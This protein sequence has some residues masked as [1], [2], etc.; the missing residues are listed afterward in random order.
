MFN[1]FRF[2]RRRA[3]QYAR[4][5]GNGDRAEIDAYATAYIRRWYPTM[6]GQRG[7]LGTR[8]HESLRTLFRCLSPRQR[9]D[10]LANNAFKANG[11]TIQ[12][13]ATASN[14]C[15]NTPFRKRFC[16]V[17][18]ASHGHFDIFLVQKLWIEHREQDFLR[19]AVKS[20]D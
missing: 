6:V 10:L 11:Y 18:V 9:R 17:P 3:P 8:D 20:G 1:L 4:T 16:A 12:C 19:I 2:F 7:M 15:S 5:P 14:I 13:N